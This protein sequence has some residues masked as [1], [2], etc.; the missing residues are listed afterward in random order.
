MATHLIETQHF[1]VTIIYIHKL[2]IGRYLAV[3]WKH[4]M[5]TGYF[6]TLFSSPQ[7]SS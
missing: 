2:E 7:D 1:P 6:E 3:H 5:M 4:I